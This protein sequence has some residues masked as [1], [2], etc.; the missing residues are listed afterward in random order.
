MAVT[1]K[2]KI[3]FNLDSSAKLTNPAASAILKPKLLMIIFVLILLFLSQFL[4]LFRTKIMIVEK[5]ENNRAQISKS[6]RQGKNPRPHDR[7]R[8]LDHVSYAAQ[9]VNLSTTD[10]EDLVSDPARLY[11]F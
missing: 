9:V 11:F 2:M 3:L 4:F 5:R 8:A 10:P 1:A 6:S 7:W